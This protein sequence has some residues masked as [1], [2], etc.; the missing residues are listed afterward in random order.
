MHA[1]IIIIIIKTNIMRVSLSKK[2][3]QEHFS[4]SK[5][6][7]KYAVHRWEKLKEKMG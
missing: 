6:E 1:K 2:L 3:L 7:T 5:Y 4:E